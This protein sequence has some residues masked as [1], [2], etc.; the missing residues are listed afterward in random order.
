MQKSI[1]IEALEIL[2]IVHAAACSWLGGIGRG[3]WLAVLLLR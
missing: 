3:P 1:L 2:D